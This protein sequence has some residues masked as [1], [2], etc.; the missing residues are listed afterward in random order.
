MLVED[1][2]DLVRWRY[3][4]K[5]A[6]MGTNQLGDL[7][8]LEFFDYFFFCESDIVTHLLIELQISI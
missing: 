2:H 7:K 6:L 3:E 5:V 1:I 8:H 4:P